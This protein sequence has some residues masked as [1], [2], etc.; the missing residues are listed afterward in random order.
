ME[1]HS[2][3]HFC[4]DVVFVQDFLCVHLMDFNM[5]GIFFP[6]VCQAEI[7]TLQFYLYFEN[8]KTIYLQVFF[9]RWWNFF[10]KFNF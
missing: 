8:N 5:H 7:G 3:K 1:D 10:Q 9:F 6:S 2:S 4:T